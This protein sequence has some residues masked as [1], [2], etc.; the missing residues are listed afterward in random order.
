MLRAYMVKNYNYDVLTDPDLSDAP[1]C[2][3]TKDSFSDLS[4]VV[5]NIEN[6]DNLQR[7]DIKYVLELELGQRLETISTALYDAI[8][9]YKGKNEVGLSAAY[10]ALDEYVAQAA[11]T[12]PRPEPE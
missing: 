5:K 2:L 4:S 12:G 6:T 8:E 3:Y 1:P 9:D 7:L 11:T 10:D